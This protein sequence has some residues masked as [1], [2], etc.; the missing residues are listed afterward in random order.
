MTD[1]RDSGTPSDDGVPDP[2]PRTAPAAEPGAPAESGAPAAREPAAPATPGPASPAAP[3]YRTPQAPV[4]ALEP[5]RPTGPTFQADPAVREFEPNYDTGQIRSLPTG[6]LLTVHR[7][8][9]EPAFT[10]ELDEE[11]QRRVFSGV[12][13]ALGILGA[14]ASLFVGWALPVSIAAI[15][16]GVLGLRREADARVPAFIGIGTGIAGVLFSL[17]WIGYY[18][19]ILGALPT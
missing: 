3:R 18:A 2:L 13:V 6:Q 16:F 1:Q 12:A 4:D 14:V 11:Q 10:G 17:I 5:Y 7:P 8:Q 15:V 9:A 19:I